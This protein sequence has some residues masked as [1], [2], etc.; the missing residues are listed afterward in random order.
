MRIVLV[1]AFMIGFHAVSLAQGSDVELKKAQKTLKNLLLTD[2]PGIYSVKFD[3]CRMSLKSGSQSYWSPG[4]SSSAE[5]GRTGYF[6][7]GTNF[8]GGADA[9][10]LARSLDNYS[11]DLRVL[12]VGKIKTTV[13]PR[14]AKNTLVDLADSPESVVTPVTPNEMRERF[15]VGIYRI[16]VKTKSVEKLRTAFTQ[17]TDICS[18]RN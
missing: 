11:I 6:S 8:T 18:K 7:D 2:T 12:D 15:A 5:A 13:S 3:G 4:A 10:V 1:F 16:A 17:I 14:N 9:L